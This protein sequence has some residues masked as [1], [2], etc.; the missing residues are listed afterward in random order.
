MA[1]VFLCQAPQC[2]PSA[3]HAS[4]RARNPYS[5]AHPAPQARAVHFGP[6]GRA[7]AESVRGPGQRQH[8]LPAARAASTPP[9]S[10]RVERQRRRTSPPR[11]C[12]VPDLRVRSNLRSP[13]R[14]GSF[15]WRCKDR[16][17]KDW[18]DWSQSPTASLSPTYS[19]VRLLCTCSREM[20]CG[21]GDGS[22]RVRI[23]PSHPCTLLSRPPS[24]A[25]PRS[26]TARRTC[27]GSEGIR[28]HFPWS[29]LLATV[30]RVTHT[31][32]AR[33]FFA[34]CTCPSSRPPPRPPHPHPARRWCAC[35]RGTGASFEAD[36]PCI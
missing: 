7:S 28:T 4:Y 18:K 21:A 13:P 35:S 22:L 3:R 19:W 29:P 30:L 17:C 23:S 33:R 27:A 8:H 20:P 34:C 24:H 31:T 25:S 32:V 26:P 5:P 1:H 16:K 9:F 14:L 6:R 36:Q 2:A 15:S 10:P 11:V 12:W